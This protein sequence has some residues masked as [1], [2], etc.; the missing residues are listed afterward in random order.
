[1]LVIIAYILYGSVYSEFTRTAITEF[2]KDVHCVVCVAVCCSVLLSET[3]FFWVCVCQVVQ[4]AL[5]CVLPCVAVCALYSVCCSVL[6]RET[7]FRSDVHESG[8]V[9]RVA[10]CCS[11]LQC[12]AGCV[13]AMQCAL[14]CVLQ[15][16]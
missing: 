16:V 5:Q 10:V 6:L 7:F 14:Q 8:S 2:F 12:G 9:A 4:C 3:F 15:C 1:V 11:M 13:A